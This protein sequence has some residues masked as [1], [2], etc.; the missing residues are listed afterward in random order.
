MLTFHNN[1]T[2]VSKEVLGKHF[3]LV[4][5]YKWLRLYNVFFDQMF[6][7]RSSALVIACTFGRLVGFWLGLVLGVCY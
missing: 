4:S 1:I 3:K 5:L 6:L 7:F 2:F